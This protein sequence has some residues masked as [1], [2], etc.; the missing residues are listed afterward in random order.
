MKLY[1][2]SYKVFI[3]ITFVPQTSHLLHLP[4]AYAFVEA[5]GMN[6][7]LYSFSLIEWTKG[8]PSGS[9][10]KASTSNVGDPGSIPGLG[11]SPGEGS[12]NPLQYSCLENSKD[13]G[14]WWV[15]VHVV[16]RSQT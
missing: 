3:T 16:A 10:G 8:F 12:G 1:S 2:G 15:M 5:T 7:I 11:S 6:R 4:Q 13:R 14:A 9:G